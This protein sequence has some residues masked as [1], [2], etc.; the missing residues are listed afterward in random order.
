[1]R[2]PAQAHRLVCNWHMVPLKM[3]RPAELISESCI[4]SQTHRCADCALEN[5]EDPKRERDIRIKCMAIRV[6]KT[7]QVQEP[8]ELVWKFISDPRKVVNCLPGVQITE[9][10]DD[11]T[12]KGAIKVQVGPSVTAY[13]GQVQI[14]RLDDQKHEIEFL[15]KGEDIRD[16]GSASVKMTGRVQSLPDGSTEVV[17]VAEVNVG[18]LLAQMG[19][20]MIQEVSN[21]IFA[22]F[23]S[24]IAARLQQERVSSSDPAQ[25]RIPTE[26]VKPIQ[27]LPMILSAARHSVA[28]SV[29]RI[30]KRPDHR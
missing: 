20:R 15:G 26:E 1:M 28:G 6:E 19:G 8:L 4:G 22:V 23:S 25:S 24:N 14:E 21:Q 9:A 7:F 18:G 2:D 10:V 17:S 29:W 27:A 30:F 11:L 12:F 3:G 5:L 16:K 13:K